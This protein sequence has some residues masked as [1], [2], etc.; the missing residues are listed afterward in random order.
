MDPLV[1]HVIQFLGHAASEGRTHQV[2]ET[3]CNRILENSSQ[4]PILPLFRLTDHRGLNR[5]SCLLT[6]YPL[7]RMNLNLHLKVFLEKDFNLKS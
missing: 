7:P 3:I 6:S 2:Y 1:T 4:G 5:P